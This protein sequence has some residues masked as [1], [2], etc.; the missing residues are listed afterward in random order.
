MEEPPAESLDGSSIVRIAFPDFWLSAL[1]T[2]RL[3]EAG[4][5]LAIP[6]RANGQSQSQTPSASRTEAYFTTTDREWR[7]QR[8]ERYR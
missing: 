7:Q 4:V 5:L 2:T 6:F 8:L 1:L 3:T